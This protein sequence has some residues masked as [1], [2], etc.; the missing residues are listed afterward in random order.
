MTI[1]EIKIWAEE[2]KVLKRELE[3]MTRD[4][5]EEC[6]LNRRLNIAFKQVVHQDKYNE[7][8]K[9]FNALRCDLIDIIRQ[10]DAKQ[11]VS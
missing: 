4:Y 2:I 8:V 11:E 6:D 9:Q 3:S 10:N 7:V 5:V 1:H